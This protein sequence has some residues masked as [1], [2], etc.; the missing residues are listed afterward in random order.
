MS[1]IKYPEEIKDEYFERVLKLKAREYGNNNM[2]NRCN[3]LSGCIHLP[4]KAR[5]QLERERAFKQIN[6]QKL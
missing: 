4:A 3:N 5:L 6:G 2:F 1:D